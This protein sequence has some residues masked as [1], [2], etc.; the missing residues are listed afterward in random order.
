MARVLDH[1]RPR[2]NARL[3]LR[4]AGLAPLATALARAAAKNL[5]PHGRKHRV[6]IFHEAPKP[7]I[8]APGSVGDACAL[9]RDPSRQHFGN[10][11]K[12]AANPGF[13]DRLTAAAEAKKAM[14]AR[15]KPKPTVVAENLVDRE[16]RRQQELEAVRQARAEDKERQRVE[17][18][19]A[20]EAARQARL[21]DEQAMLDAKRS[22][23]K[24]RKQL[25]KM[26]AQSRRAARLS[27]YSRG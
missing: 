22:Q 24:E 13:N 11:M 23:R 1:R 18:A 10:Y 15:F 7:T 4:L 3:A 17:R 9:G 20:E 5:A 8:C 27:M 25:E 6:D 12:Q 26:D 2:G 16:T 14:L 19:A 21:A